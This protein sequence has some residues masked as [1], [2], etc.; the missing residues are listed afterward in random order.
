MQVQWGRFRGA[1][2][3]GQMQRVAAVVV[4]RWR[5]VEVQRLKVRGCQRWELGGTAAV[6]SMLIRM[7]DAKGE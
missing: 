1:G 3:E 4:L 2:A 7:E 6:F 5:G